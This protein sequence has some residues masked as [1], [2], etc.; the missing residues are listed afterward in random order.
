M[1]F[2]TQTISFS[3]IKVPSD[4]VG[5]RSLSVATADN[6]QLFGVSHIDGTFTMTALHPVV[7]KRTD[8]LVFARIID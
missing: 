6:E 2:G 5:K 3:S 4:L 1:T 8:R 7:L